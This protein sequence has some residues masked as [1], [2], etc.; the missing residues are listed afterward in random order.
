MNRIA[1]SIGRALESGAFYTDNESTQPHTALLRYNR[2]I[3]RASR[4]AYAKTQGNTMLQDPDLKADRLLEILDLERIEENLYRGENEDPD[5]GRLFGGQVMSQALTAARRTTE[6]DRYPNSLHGYFIRPGQSAQPVLYEVERIRDGRSFV[7]RRV[8]AIQNGAAIFNADVSFHREEVGL[9]HSDSMPNVAFP[10]ELSDDVTLARQAPDDDSRYPPWA[11]FGRPFETRLV[12]RPE[13]LRKPVERYWNPVW[14]RF[15]RRDVEL[16]TQIGHS[17]L[18]YA[19]DM[20]MVSTSAVPHAETVSRT[21]LQMASLDHSIWFHRPFRVD[22]WLLFVR[23][24]STATGTRGMNHAEFYSTDGQLVA[25][26]SQEGLMRL[27][28]HQ[29]PAAGSS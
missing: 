29:P 25:S 12:Y 2:L 20:G 14:M 19:S 3:S 15:R 26:V 17:L 5:G 13:S 22:R 10:A 6:P 9:S 28:R 8:V 16:D 23:R 4:A 24:T 21:Q 7:T 18:A 1:T 11:R 27:G